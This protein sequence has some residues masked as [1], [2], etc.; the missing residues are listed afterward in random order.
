MIRIFFLFIIFCLLSCSKSEMVSKS[1][2]SKTY[3][4]LGDSYTIGEG[5]AEAERYPVILTKKL[6]NAGFNFS[7]PKIIATTGWTTDD[8][9]KAIENENLNKNYDLVS[10]LIGVNNQ[11]RGYDVSLY[12]RE[13][14]QLLQK[15]IEL[16]GKNPQ[17]VFVVS[18][19]DYGVTPFAQ[20]RDPQK[21]SEEI[22][23][24]NK[25]NEEI[26]K[27]AGVSY[28]NI[29]PVSRNAASDNT[30]LAE[31]QLHPSGKMYREWTE[32]IFPVVQN[33]LR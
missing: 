18:I 23:L 25:I 13:F 30:L 24:Y 21:I 14:R 4:A 22:D 26:S 12:E 9:L 31:D 3:L 5:V 11:Y 20:S 33:M 1:N 2:D 15:A 32:L 28:I 6:Q 8:L 16:A 27:E 7:S 17:R 29:T 10:L 19:P